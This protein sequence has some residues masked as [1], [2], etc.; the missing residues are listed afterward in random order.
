MSCIPVKI[1][2]VHRTSGTELLSCDQY[3]ITDPDITTAEVV[4]MFSYDSGRVASSLK[5]AGDGK[6]PIWSKNGGYHLDENRPFWSQ[7]NA[8][9]GGFGQPAE[10]LGLYVIVAEF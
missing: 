5:E 9:R 4:A 8:R 3:P 6:I 2:S 10:Q 7:I 1:I